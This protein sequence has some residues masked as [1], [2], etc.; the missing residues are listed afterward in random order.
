MTDHKHVKGWK[1]MPPEKRKL[2]V[3]GILCWFCNHSY[4]G[5][6]MTLER[7][8]NVVKYLEADKLGDSL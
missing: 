6:S 1:A 3:R 4:L 8:R 2:Y 7:A 5:R